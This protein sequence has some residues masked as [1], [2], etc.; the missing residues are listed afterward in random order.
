[1][2][3]HPGDL[4]KYVSPVIHKRGGTISL[5]EGDSKGEN[6]GKRSGFSRSHGS[7]VTCLCAG[8]MRECRHRRRQY[9]QLVNRGVC[10]CRRMVLVVSP[11]LFRAGGVDVWMWR[12]CMC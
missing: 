10:R 2:E 7:R 11:G 5:T 12:G 3:K 8:G 4:E 1:M 9:K 6:Q